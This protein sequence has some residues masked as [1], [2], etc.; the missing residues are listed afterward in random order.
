MNPKGIRRRTRDGVE[1][2]CCKSCGEWKS[3]PE[4]PERNIRYTPSG[5]H[6]SCRE[7]MKVKRREYRAKTKDYW[8]AVGYAKDR[9]DRAQAREWDKVGRPAVTYPRF[10]E[11]EILVPMIEALMFQSDND[12]AIAAHEAGTTSRTLYAIRVGERDTVRWDLAER[13]AI[14]A[15]MHEKFL[16]AFPLGKAGWNRAGDRYCRCCGRSD[17]RH[18]GRGF[19]LRCYQ[20]A[21][22][23]EKKGQIHRQPP[24][25]RWMRS[26]EFMR[27]IRCKSFERKHEAYGMCRPCHSAVTRRNPVPDAPLYRKHI[28]RAKAAKDASRA[29][30]PALTF[31]PSAA[32]GDTA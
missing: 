30:T 5:I 14:A 21:W 7:C 25:E 32:A 2:F 24:A 13:I 29:Y 20:T 8:L 17:I 19:C 23:A 6:G 4:F 1:Q 27:C 12:S 11:R 26:D 18:A 31:P 28:E 10:V 9:A 15:H 16:D 22:V 3:R